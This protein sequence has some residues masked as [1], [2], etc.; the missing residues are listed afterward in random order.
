MEPTNASLPHTMR[1]FELL[2]NTSVAFSVPSY[3]NEI[4]RLIIL[5]Q[6]VSSLQCSIFLIWCY[7]LE[8]ITCTDNICIH[9]FFLTKGCVLIIEL[10]LW[11]VTGTILLMGPRW[12]DCSTFLKFTVVNSVVKLNRQ[13]CA[14]LISLS[15]FKW[16]K[17]MVLK[18]LCTSVMAWDR[19]NLPNSALF[20]VL[21]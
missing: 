5:T 2:L 1:C 3:T 18:W 15:A 20:C 19:F 6:C 4:A 11:T 13:S 12:Q 10:T 14:G 16:K 17:G 8:N 9:C 21:Y 7:C